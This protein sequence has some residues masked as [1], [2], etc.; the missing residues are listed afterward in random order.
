RHAGPAEN[1]IHAPLRREAAYPPWIE[2]ARARCRVA[3]GI[4]GQGRLAAHE[5]GRAPRIPR[6]AQRAAAA[7]AANYWTRTFAAK[8]RAAFE[9]APGKAGVRKAPE[10]SAFTLSAR[11]HV[12]VRGSNHC[13]R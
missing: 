12:P 2:C 6:Y 5:P 10:A 9:P 8:S 1:G 13:Q 4:P 7:P 11:L 3:P